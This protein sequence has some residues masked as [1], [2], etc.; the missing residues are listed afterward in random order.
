VWLAV[1]YA[2]R[3]LRSGVR[4]FRIFLAC[5]ALGVAAIA[6][7][8]STASAFRAGLAAE[9][10]DIV[11]GDIAVTIGQ[12][13]F[14]PREQ[15]ALRRFGPV[16]YAVSVA[17]MGEAASGE[18]HLV[19]FRGVSADYPLAGRVELQGG[20]A[21]TP[22]LAPVGGVAGAAVEA[23]V[24]QRLG[25]RLGDRFTVGSVPLIA[26]A[27]LLSEPDRL[28]RGFTLGPRVLTRI[29]AVRGGGLLSGLIPFGETARI[30]LPAG[31]D[32]ARAKAELT[33]ALRKAGPG[34]WRMSDRTN[35]APGLQRLIASLQYFL[36]FIGFAALVAG[37]LGIQQAVSAHLLSRRP[38]IAVLKTLG[39]SGG[40][41]RNIYLVQVAALAV[42]GISIGVAIGADVPLLL[43]LAVRK[44]LP[45]PALFA[46]YP[47]PLL[48]AA[49]FGALATGA[50]SL[51]P[52]GR[53][54]ATA[55]AALLRSDLTARPRPGIEWAGA[56]LCALA[57]AALA[58]VEAPEPLAGAAMVGGVIAAFGALRLLGV[59]AAR[60]S[61]PL[62]R[63][64][65]GAWRLGLANLAAPGSAAGAAAPAIGLGV[66]LL[67]AVVLIQSSLLAQVMD[68]AP[69]TA[70][71]LVFVGIP[72][73]RAGAFDD[74]VAGALGHRLS[75]QNYFRAPFFT[76]RI[77]AVKGEPA[78]AVRASPGDRWILDHDVSMSALAS[79]PPGAGVTAGRW[80]APNYAG[81]PLVALSLDAAKGAGLR[82]GD[83]IGLDVLGRTI[84]ARVAVLRK[85]DVAA[86]GAPFP[87]ILDPHALA[88]AQLKS[89]AVAHA[90]PA[91]E[92]RITRALGAGFPDVDVISVREA[93]ESAAQIFDRLVLAVRAAAA[94]AGVA[95]LLVLAGAI[96]ARARQRAREAAVLQALGASR[97]Q[98][99]G[100]YAIEYGAVGLIAGSA[101]V[102]IGALAAWP[103]VTQIFE[104]R[105]SLDWT[106]VAVLALAAAAIAAIGGLAAGLIALSRPPA[107]TL[108]ETAV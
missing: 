100:A 56:A 108:R 89:L 49:G 83:Q 71:Q 74:A 20:G 107:R 99:L 92:G 19:E 36:T 37:G 66:A 86:F 69:R 9:A 16:A 11:G 26:R 76:G 14:T 98:I 27:V 81:P 60:A 25:L 51:A 77:S 41:V 62:R 106:G 12:R 55:P 18:R 79:P 4:G 52:L 46:V 13:E 34:G 8:G 3:E 6:A 5:L 2:L 44:S 23:G 88:G 38:A 61:R 31:T 103:I 54:R 87:I 42:L 53:A 47:Q 45:V 85:V 7:A 24:L 75:A 101:G 43:G 10:R 59:A 78:A 22:A 58:V 35:A 84:E 64:T 80:W 57:L 102:L 32:L 21:L 48:T 67:A 93:L 105:W 95:G 68:V 39:A 90:S 50:F 30:A 70:P 29:G 72:G 28:A 104:A 97:G 73:D 17:A 94:V 82:L 96:A 15:A 33:A 91:Q 63:L 40:L 1:R 65:R